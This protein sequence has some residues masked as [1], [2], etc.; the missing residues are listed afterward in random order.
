MFEAQSVAESL[1]VTA[2][3]LV[4]RI[5]LVD[6]DLASQVRRAITSAALNLAEGNRRAGRDRIARFR[7][8]AG[9]CGEAAAAL[10]IAVG[11]GYLDSAD[12]APALGLADRLGAI[13][14]RLRHPRR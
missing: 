11:W 1:V 7:I 4:E 13:L 6:R 8:A 3:P 9:E 10:R 5:A 2:R 12:V 14:W